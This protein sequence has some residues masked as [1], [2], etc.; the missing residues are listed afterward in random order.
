MRTI[1]ADLAARYEAEGWW[2]R[3][4]LGQMLERGL[5]AAPGTPFRVHS[6]ERPWSGTFRDVELVAR[7]L[8]AGLRERGVGPGDAVA[9]QLPNWMEAAAVF[10]A[11]AFLGATVVP[12]VHFYGRKEVGHILTAVR[13]RVFITAERFGRLAHHPDL[14]ANVP[15]VGIVS[16]QRVG[17]RDTSGQG[18]GDGDAGGRGSDGRDVSGQGGGGRDVSGL[19]GG[20]QGGGGR[21]AGGQGSG[22]RDASGQGG[23]GRDTSGQGGGGRDT[24]G[25]GCGGQ[26][27]GGREGVGWDFGALLAAEPLVGV[28][29]AAPDGPALIA[30]TSGTTSEPK[31]VVHSHRT[32][33]FETR[34]LAGLYP[35]DRG[36]QLTAAPVGHFIGMINAFLIPVLDGTPVNL[37]DVWDPAQA[38]RLLK[39]EGL[40]V[41][42]GAAYYMTSLLDHPDFTEGHLANL[43]YAG[44]GG[45]AVPAAVAARLEGLG[46]TVWR[47][48]GSTEHP[49]ITGSKATAPAAKRLYTDGDPLPGV[50][51]RL[52]DDGEILSRGPDLCL[53]YTDPELTARAFD[54]DGWYRTGDIGVIDGDGYLTI[55]DRKADVIIRGGENISALEVE[56]AL[57]ALPAVAEAAVVAAPD[58]RLGE[59]AAAFVRVRPGHRP[60]GLPEVREH[61]DRLGMARQKWPEELHP[62]QELPRTAS[63]KVQKF[64]LRRDIAANRV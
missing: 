21:D 34:Q 12:I 27:G 26:G 11:S 4:T 38:L 49:S 51:I 50:E 18:G 28:L 33:G 60:P 40:A 52:A 43:R 62:V 8:A 64:I 31:G 37:A 25:Q 19:G 61:L 13:P 45:A 47:S 6:A 14:T 3:D 53:G 7:R 54:A 10:W 41:G 17:G 56:E 32:L 39:D 29:D 30:F 9:F 15:T 63:G 57:L 44:L 20:G 59:R 16:A 42:G 36:R 24:S 22:G 5:A 48:Y 58:P 1:P 2:T 35:P 46:I 23:G 55:T